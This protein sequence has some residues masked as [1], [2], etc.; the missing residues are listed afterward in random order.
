[1][2]EVVV[3]TMVVTAM[4]E[5]TVRISIVCKQYTWLSSQHHEIFTLISLSS[6]YCSLLFLHR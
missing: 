5:A 3:E 2:K 4:E 1:M 6:C